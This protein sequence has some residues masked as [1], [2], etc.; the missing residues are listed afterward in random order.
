MPV[1]FPCPGR[2][3]PRTLAMI[4]RIGGVSLNKPTVVSLTHH[5]Y[6]NLNG[7]RSW[8]TVD[9]LQLT[10]QTTKYLETDEENVPNRN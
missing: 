1:V 4:R 3:L 2:P 7:H 6:F 5:P 8:S 10:V 9:D